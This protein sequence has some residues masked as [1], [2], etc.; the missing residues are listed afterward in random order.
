MYLELGQFSSLAV[1]PSMKLFRARWLIPQRLGSRNKLAGMDRERR[2]YHQDVYCKTPN[3]T[4]RHGPFVL[5]W[6]VP[7]PAVI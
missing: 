2:M 4:G 3:K 7:H 1:V 6:V 5:A